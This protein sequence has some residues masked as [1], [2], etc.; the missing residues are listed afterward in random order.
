MTLQ[1]ILIVDDDDVVR[2][3]LEKQT[4]KIIPEIDFFSFSRGSQ[5]LN[6]LT[7]EANTRIPV[8]QSLLFLDIKMPE[9]SGWDVIERLATLPMP[10]REHFSQSTRIY[11]YSSSIDP[12]D[13]A[14]ATQF[15][16]IRE[17]LIKPIT[18]DKLRAILTGS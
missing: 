11:I 3:I 15:P 6:F 4:Q 8:K 2:L 7:E 5:L 14:K 13:L 18:F 9:L 10:Y 1:R 17:Y 12:T 16:Q